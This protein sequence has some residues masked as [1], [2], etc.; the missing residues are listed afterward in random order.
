MNLAYLIRRP[1]NPH[2]TLTLSFFN[3]ETLPS[4][5][6]LTKPKNQFL[7]SL[8][9]IIKFLTESS[10]NEFRLNP[11][12]AEPHPVELLFYHSDDNPYKQ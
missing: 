7:P 9:W 12:L 6:I 10:Q 11:T 8:D 4:T 1:T 5:H 2:K 3:P